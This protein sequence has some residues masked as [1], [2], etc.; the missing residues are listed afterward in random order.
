MGHLQ[1][2]ELNAINNRSIETMRK[3]KVAEEMSKKR[4]QSVDSKEWRETKN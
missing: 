1:K 3:T 4:Y 2:M